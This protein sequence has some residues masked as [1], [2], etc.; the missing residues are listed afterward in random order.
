M[1]LIPIKR[2][3]GIGDEIMKKL[4]R[5]KKNIEADKSL[6]KNIK[7]LSYY[8]VEMFIEDVE[9]Y[10]KAIK[11]GRMI[12]SI[13]SVSRSGMSRTIKFVSMEKNKYSKQ[14]H[15]CNFYQLFKAL[16]YTES[17]AKDHYFT[18]GGCGM[19]MIF[20][21]NYTNIHKFERLG[22][23]NKKQCSSYAQM[24]PTTI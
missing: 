1:C 16:G 4:E 18:I 20:H 14:F 12:N 7:N 3:K 22:F 23:I 13:G 8:S 10:I 15:V 24:T 2:P 11:D 21:T 17:R 6:M 9:R 19:D 5:I